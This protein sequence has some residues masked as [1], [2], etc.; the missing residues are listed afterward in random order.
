MRTKGKLVIQ[1]LQE[2]QEPV[3]SEMH[4]HEILAD[5]II[6][7]LQKFKFNFFLV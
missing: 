1:Y 5:I 2:G 4:V 3:F 7:D 6:G